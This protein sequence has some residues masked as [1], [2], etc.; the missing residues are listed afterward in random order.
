VQVLFPVWHE[1][2]ETTETGAA[3]PAAPATAPTILVVDDEAPIRRTAQRSLERLGY[4]VLTAAD[5]EEGL[6]LFEEH[7]D[8]VALECR[9]W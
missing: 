2:L 8:E 3:V 7:A 5:G 1:K 6:R 9:T 4:R